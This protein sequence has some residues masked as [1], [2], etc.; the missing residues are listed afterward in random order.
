MPPDTDTTTR[1]PLR[2]RYEELRGKAIAITDAAKA[3]GRDTLNE[4][5]Q[6]DV[7]LYVKQAQDVA[8]KIKQADESAAL[9]KAIGDLDEF[10][11]HG[12]ELT[13]RAGAAVRADY[14]ATKAY[15]PNGEAHPWTRAFGHKTGFA[16]GVKAFD[17]PSGAVPMIPLAGD[18][19][20]LLA[21]AANGLVNEIGVAPWPVAGSKAFSYLRQTVRTEGAA[22]WNPDDATDKP[23]STYGFEAATAEAQYVAHIAEPVREEWLADY[24]SLNGWITREMVAGIGT[25]LEDVVV[26]AS[27]TP[28]EAVGIL[29]DPAVLTQPF[30]TDAVTSIRE[31]LVLLEEAGVDPATMVVAMRPGDWSDIG[32]LQD[33]TTAYLQQGGPFAGPPGT[34]WGARV[35]RTVGLAAGTAIVGRLRGN[36]R[37]FERERPSIVWGT[38]TTTDGARFERNTVAARCEGRYALTIAQPGDVLTVDIAAGS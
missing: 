28:P 15:E 22:I 23:A 38:T 36:V 6:A 1:S 2:D 17:A 3:A 30:A 16:E 19:P 29:F 5:E 21:R 31:A 25:A 13:R 35:V 10:R 11:R 26:N 14:D 20:L 8:A 37:L 12:E 4:Q 33:N 32:A 9:L 24:E 18:T 7:A 27:G 34:L